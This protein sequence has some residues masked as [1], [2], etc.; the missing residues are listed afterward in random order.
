M[1]DKVTFSGRETLLTKGLEKAAEKAEQNFVKSSSILPA[2]PVKPVEK[3]VQKDIYTSP[4]APIEVTETSSMPSINRNGL[5]F[6][7]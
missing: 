1:I 6:F 2:L 3:A 7:A 5:D 4:Y